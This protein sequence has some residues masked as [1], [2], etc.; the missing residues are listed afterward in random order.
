MNRNKFVAVAS[1]SL[2]LGGLF[3]AGVSTQAVQAAPSATSQPRKVTICHRTRSTTN[4]YV[5]ITVSESSIGNAANKHGGSKHD[6]YPSGASK[7]NPNVFDRTKV[8]TANQKKWG[9]IIPNVYTDGTAFTA[10][11]AG[12]NYSGVGIDIYNG[13][14]IHAGA[15]KAMSARDLFESEKASGEVTDAQIWEDLSELEADEFASA[16]TACGGSFASCTNP[17]LLGAASVTTTTAPAAGV[18]T[19]VAGSTGG[20]T[21]TTVAGSKSTLTAGKG[22]LTVLVWIDADRDGTQGDDEPVYPGVSCTATGPGGVTKTAVSDSSGSASFVDLDP[23]AWSVTCN[24]ADDSLEKVYDSD[25]TVDWTAA[26]TVEAGKFAEARFGAAGTSSI[27]VTGVSTDSVKIKWAG[28]DGELDTDDDVVFEVPA[29][30]GKVT[31][32]GLPAGKYA[33]TATGDFDSADEVV[34]V[35]VAKGG[36]A[37]AVVPTLSKTGLSR[38]PLM[39][40]LAALMLMAGAALLFLRRRPV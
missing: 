36:T 24:L 15:C 1:A 26:V 16:L 23:G 37:D 14:G 21:T 4:P 8:Y 35:E 7:P 17:S 20:A 2:I 29:K 11:G 22:G 5:R 38:E 12:T 28:V 6:A 3:V 30:G 13:T 25:T 40:L 9:D 39:S 19:T 18:T 32:A 10:A 33:V 27:E 31:V 34:T